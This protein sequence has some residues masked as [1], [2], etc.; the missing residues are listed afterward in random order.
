MNYTNSVFDFFKSPKWF[1]NML[2]GTVCLFI[3]VVGPMVLSGWLIQGFFG[4]R[5]ESD[6]AGF[7]EFDFNLFGKHLERGAWPFLVNLVVSLVMTVILYAVIGVLMIL[8]A[9]VTAGIGEANSDAAGVVVIISMGA[10]SIA[11]ILIAIPMQLVMR[12]MQLRAAITQDFAAAFQFGFIKRFIAL[13][14]KEQILATFFLMFAGLALMLA[15]AV[16]VCVGM[17]LAMPVI[18]FAMWHLDHQL[19]ELY[20]QRGGE[21][22]PV[23]PKLSN[24]TLVLPIPLR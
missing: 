21:P 16:V 13:T 23:S 20:L 10:I 6:A 4:A 9:M 15:G 7:P 5:K 22:I 1:I 17:Y 18:F 8:V 19:Y 12:T 24:A 2:L 3:P 14:W 11:S